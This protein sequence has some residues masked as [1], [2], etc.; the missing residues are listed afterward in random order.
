MRLAKREMEWEN[1]FFQIVDESLL[2]VPN[3]LL[4]FEG[5]EARE[6]GDIIFGGCLSN[7]SI[8][9]LNNIN[10]TNVDITKKDNVFWKLV[11]SSDFQTPSRFA[12]YPDRVVFC[13]NTSVDNNTTCTNSNHVTAYV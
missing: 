1:I 3:V 8:S 7:C 10:H 12:E 6:G 2:K 5:N 9:Q 11:N 4:H 13:K